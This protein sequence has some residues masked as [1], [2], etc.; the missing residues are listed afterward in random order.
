MFEVS[1]I[2]RPNEVMAILGSSGSG[3]TTLL[4][5]LN[6]R[7]KGK[8]NVQGDIRVN[9]ELI[10][11]TEMI[12]SVSGYVQQDEMFISSL[13][14]R[15]HLIFQVSRSRAPRCLIDSNVTDKFVLGNASNGQEH[16]QAGSNEARR[17]SLDRG[18]LPRE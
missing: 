6:S 1:G 15:E 2:A 11:S 13:K 10:R 14:V 17:G 7:N 12:A 8:L 3:K 18:E 16:D 9:G 4:N 5:V